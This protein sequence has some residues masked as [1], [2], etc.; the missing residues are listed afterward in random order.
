MHADRRLAAAFLVALLAA[1]ASQQSQNAN[2][3]QMTDNV[4]RPQCTAMGIAPNTPQGN[5]CIFRLFKM[6]ADSKEAA[7]I[8]MQQQMGQALS[9]YGQAIQRIPQAPQ[10]PVNMQPG[11]VQ[12]DSPK[13]SICH[14]ETP[15]FQQ[16]QLVCVQQ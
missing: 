10:R 1:C 2:I 13:T 6:W 7:S 16:P 9:N 11:N 15:S 4:W 14:W 12:V 5:D 3:E 8:A